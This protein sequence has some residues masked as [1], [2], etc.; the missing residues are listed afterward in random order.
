MRPL[1]GNIL[2]FSAVLRCFA[3][4]LRRLGGKNRAPAARAVFDHIA[5]RQRP[6]IASQGVPEQNNLRPTEARPREIASSRDALLAMTTEWETSLTCPGCFFPVFIS[7]ISDVLCLGCARSNDLSF[8]EIVD[9]RRGVA[10]IGEDCVVVGAELGGDADLGR[11][12]R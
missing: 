11:R 6:V 3:L 5:S 1:G 8:A 7:A 9:L 4:L 2:L 10:E 12:F